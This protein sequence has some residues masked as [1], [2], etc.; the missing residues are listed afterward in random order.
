MSHPLVHA[1]HAPSLRTPLGEFHAVRPSI[2]EALAALGVKNLGQLIAYLPMRHERLE[3]EAKVA[4]LQ[5]D[6]IVTARGEITATRIIRKGTRPRFEAVLC[7]DTGRL[8]LVWFN[9]LFLRGKIVPGMVLRVTGKARAHGPGVQMANPKFDVITPDRSTPVTTEAIVRPVYP[10]SEAVNSRQVH[11]AVRTLLPVGLPLIEDHLPA[12]FRAK[13]HLPALR[14][15]YRMIHDP[16]NETEA[17]EAR[18][19][20]VYDEFLMLQL[21][22]HLKRAHLREMLRAPALKWTE[23]IDG[24]IRARIPFALTAAQDRVI[25]EI[26][27]DLTGTT[28]TNRLIQGDVGSGKTVV[29]LYA[30]LMAAASGHQSALMAPTELLAEQHYASISALLAGSDVPME[31]L[32]GSMT[33]AEREAALGR[34]ASGK[35]GIVIGT[36][37]ILTGGVRFAS[38]ALA[39]TDEQHR[40]GVQQRAG[41]REK[42]GAVEKEDRELTPHVLVMTATPIPRTLALTAFG[43]LDISTIAGMPPGR[44]PVATRLVGPEKA[45]EVYAYVRERL[46]AGDQAYIVVPA[47]AAPRAG[48]AGGDDEIMN[49]AALQAALEVEGGPLAGVRIAPMHGKLS[50]ELREVV[51]ARF[52]AGEIKALVATTVI[53]VGVDVPNATVMVIENAD[54]FGLA[55]LHQLRGRIGRSGK[56][57]VCILIADAKTEDAGARL[58]AM[59]ELRDGFA[60]AEKDM[61]IRGPGEVFGT[62]QAGMP[63]FK[64]ADLVKDAALLRLARR[65]AAAWIKRSPHLDQPEESLLHKRLLKSHGPWLELGDVG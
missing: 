13:K 33:G 29:A 55:Q 32:T 36:H 16:A 46:D 2:V 19:R 31:L 45:G 34:I 17:R 25:K 64:I 53:E 20:L 7:D 44:V 3:A 26:I 50:R 58:A 35:T 38:L 30:M 5:K 54:R 65:D 49:V 1:G 51:M 57:S 60:I 42:G 56:K 27:A 6:S 14:D 11:A 62:R 24:R 61:E 52:R 43:D 4:N 10:A 28:P 15:A 18:R 39:I 21:G 8:D 9:G 40:F 48:G 22:V 59:V 63:P 37:A 41:L 12:E 47:I 23:A